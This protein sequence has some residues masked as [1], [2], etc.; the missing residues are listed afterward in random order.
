MKTA[1]VT[2]M[3]SGPFWKRLA[4]S[5]VSTTGL[6]LPASFRRPTIL[7][8]KNSKPTLSQR[9][10]ITFPSLLRLGGRQIPTKLTFSRHSFSPRAK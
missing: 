5:K 6:M 10:A 7:R 2:S 3:P 4:D 1:L 8:E 9:F